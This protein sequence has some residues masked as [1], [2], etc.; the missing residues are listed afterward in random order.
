MDVNIVSGGRASRFL[1]FSR[2]GIR[3]T[4][5]KKGSRAELIV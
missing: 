4:L 1:I 3:V 5:Q 2:D